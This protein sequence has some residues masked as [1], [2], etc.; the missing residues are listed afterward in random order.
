MLESFSTQAIKIIEDAKAIASNLNSKVVGS[1]HLLL[2]LYQT[3]DSICRFLLQEKNINYENLLD[4]LSNI[5]VIH[6]CIDKEIKFTDKFQEIILK[7]EDLIKEVDSKYVF[8]EHLFYSMLDDGSNIG[9]EIINL[10]GINIH[11][12]KEDIE[13]IYS[14]YE[15]DEEI[16]YPYLINLTKK[17]LV[18]PYILR[19]N[20]IERIN[21]ILDK[22]QKNN[23][24]LIGSAGVGK[25]AIVEGLAKNRTNDVIYQLDL[26]AT[27]SGTK[28][29][30]ELEEKILKGVE[31]VKDQN[32]ILFIDEIHNVVGAGS[33]DGSLDIANIL[34][35][36]LS[37]ND[38]S[39][40]G[41]T[42]LEEYNRFID[43]DKALMRR[44]Q[45]IFIS[46]PSLS[47]TK[48]IIKGIKESYET[49][50]NFEISDESI[51]LLI[52][53][54]NIY[55]PHRP[56]PD[57]AIDLLDEIG[58]RKKHAKYKNYSISNLID[59]IINDITNIKITKKEQIKN[60]NLNYNVLKPY[61]IRFINRVKVYPNIFAYLVEEN[62]DPKYLLDDLLRIF[63][64]KE[65]M[66]LEIDLSNYSDPTM[67][68]NLLGS[69]R[70]YVGYE[71][72][73]IL[74]EHIFKYPISLIYF[75][76]Y[77]KAHNQ[78]ISK[79]DKIMKSSFLIDSKGRKI[80]L[81]NTM[82][83]YDNIIM[84]NNL[85]FIENYKNISNNCLK[86]IYIDENKE[87]YVKLLSTNNIKISNIDNISINT[88]DQIIY[89]I[90]LEGE[91]VY[92][93]VDDKNYIKEKEEVVLL[94]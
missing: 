2:A 6:K 69:S 52:N 92:Y 18:H 21:Y 78:I 75:K 45:P 53:K 41:A 58:S 80:N 36:Y 82:F 51:D 17:E 61:Y 10:L 89:N 49:H 12:L 32:A 44:F 3:K 84:H 34:K 9:V 5:T 46:E 30:G 65:E 43:K 26:G 94:N 28:Y 15:E 22:K 7:S 74:S 39:I 67:I 27:I 35:P 63:N 33:N 71:Q 24:L 1:E 42:T 86:N 64:F 37:R 68:N 16:P 87:M 54:A 29:R 40:I 90:L 88:L 70:G 13:D 8:D 38:I 73:G 50:H 31:Y 57:K 59:E 19:E 91:G 56:F 55:I 81:Q 47:E 83:I 79:L 72:G 93:I 20:Y 11:E 77:S 4:T 23:P 76:N 60:Y 62:F 48:T 14:F 66:Y 25:T 85:G